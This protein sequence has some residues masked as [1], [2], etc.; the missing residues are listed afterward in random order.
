MSTTT[1]STP[2]GAVTVRP[3]PEGRA[4]DLHGMTIKTNHDGYMLQRDQWTPEVA[5]LLARLDGVELTEEHWRI[6]DYLRRYYAEY[7]ISPNVR[8]LLRHLQEEWGD[9]QLDRDH[10]YQLFPKG[11]AF[12]GTKFAGLPKPY[13]CIDG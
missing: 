2:T 1:L 6:L 7:L 8:I 10:L 3:I 5:E 9:A 13:D 4:I 12:Q 11:P